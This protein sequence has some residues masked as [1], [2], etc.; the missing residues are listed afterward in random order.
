MLDYSLKCSLMNLHLL[1]ML[2]P[3]KN[4]LNKLKHSTRSRLYVSAASY[5][6]F[7]TTSQEDVTTTSHQCVS[8]TSHTS[9]KWNTQR[10]LSGMSPR[11][12]SGTYPWRPIS[13]SLWRL[14]LVPNETLN[15]VAVVC[16]H[17]VSELR[18]CDPC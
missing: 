15:N 13:T 1:K 6:N 2:T 4:S 9:L 10:R 17:H 16:L 7:V 8:S 18:C 5:W 3:H 14:L 11:R 12:I